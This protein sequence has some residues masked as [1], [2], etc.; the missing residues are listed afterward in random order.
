MQNCE[1]QN[2]LDVG[3]SIVLCLYVKH[4]VSPVQNYQNVAVK[5]LLVLFSSL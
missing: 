4:A 2:E 5:F 1:T 3:K